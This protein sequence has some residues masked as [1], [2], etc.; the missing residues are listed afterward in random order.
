MNKIL[1]LNLPVFSARKQSSNTLAQTYNPP[2][3][4]L[5]IGTVLELNGYKPV[6]MDLCANIA[7][8]SAVFKT[9]S[10]DKPL[11][12]AISTYTENIDSAV[13]IAKAIKTKFK[14]I[15]IVFG[16]PH[17][18]LEPEYGIRSRYVDFIV[19]KEGEA[20]FIELV[21]AIE[22]NQEIIRF[23]DIPGII[24]KQ[25]DKV[26]KN[27]YRKDITD[28]DLLPIV[29]RELMEISSY[30]RIINIITSRGCPGNCIYCAATALSGAKYRVRDTVNTLLEV[31]L[32]LN[33]FKNTRKVVYFIDDTFTGIPSRVADFIAL[34][35]RY[36]LDFRWR[37]ESRV[38]VMT[39]ELIRNMAQNQCIG[40]VY[41]I[42]SGSQQVLD[43]IRKNINLV[44]AEEIID[45]SCK[46]GIHVCLNFMLGHYCDTR[47][48][49]EM[50]LEFIKRMF[51]KHR[52]DAMLTY[53]TPFP[54]T[55][56]YQHRDR[57]GLNLIS[58]NYCDFTVL[59][60]SVETANFT[61]MDQVDMYMKATP[62]ILSNDFGIDTEE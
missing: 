36:D 40:V 43:T 45:E 29:K 54:G 10:E 18:S 39:G 17:S 41:G 14:D 24:Y 57:L 56:Q 4:L 53:N 21:Q 50:T 2:L 3:G 15:K 59:T 16:G 62:Y 47:E 38:D 55:W 13:N 35:K 51:E 31:I 34:K 28:L 20:T 37:C 33:T 19:M 48:T 46:T 22:S 44:S 42:E 9:I 1:L 11:L 58:E 25:P 61:R 52:M 27:G 49:M 26:V 30:G 8:L 7:N 6:I 60:P 12:V 32:I 5:Y 23:E